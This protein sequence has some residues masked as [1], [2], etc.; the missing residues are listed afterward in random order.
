MNDGVVSV[1]GRTDVAGLDDDGG[2]KLDKSYKAG[3]RFENWA[4]LEGSDVMFES[5]EGSACEKGLAMIE[6]VESR[7]LSGL[8]LEVIGLQRTFNTLIRVSLIR[9]F[10]GPGRLIFSSHYN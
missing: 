2:V 6:R 10:K 5:L 7:C 9:A 8:S 3:S 4:Y 1:G